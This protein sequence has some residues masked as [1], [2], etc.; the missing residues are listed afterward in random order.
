LAPTAWFVLSIAG[1]AREKAAAP[2]TKQGRWD[3]K[4]YVSQEKMSDGVD[5]FWRDP[6]TCAW[7]FR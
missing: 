1:F 4:H 5:A 7:K 6:G 2:L 3:A